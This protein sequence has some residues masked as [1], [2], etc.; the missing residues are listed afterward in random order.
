MSKKQKNSRKFQPNSHI[1]DWDDEQEDEN[2]GE[3]EAPQP[4]PQ[5]SIESQCPLQASSSA[6]AWI[7][8]IALCLFTLSAFFK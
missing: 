6:A 1:E 2:E 4:R 8:L 3:R 7:L 5:K